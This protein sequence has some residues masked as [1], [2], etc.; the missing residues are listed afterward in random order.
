MEVNRVVREGFRV[1]GGCGYFFFK[2]FFG[3]GICKIF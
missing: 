3:V 2:V 1:L